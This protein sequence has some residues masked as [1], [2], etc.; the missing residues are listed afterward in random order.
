MTIN[1][2]KTIRDKRFIDF[3]LN[4]VIFAFNLATNKKVWQI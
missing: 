2:K 3:S 4:K 1:Y